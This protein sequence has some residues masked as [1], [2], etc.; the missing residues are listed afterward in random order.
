[1]ADLSND[2][3]QQAVEPIAAA[4]DGQSATGRPVADLIAADQYLAGKAAARRRRRGI[5]FTKLTTPGGLPDNGR[6]GT[7]SFDTP[8]LP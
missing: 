2:I 5:R 7:G 1:V 4:V 6:T 3:A 8:G